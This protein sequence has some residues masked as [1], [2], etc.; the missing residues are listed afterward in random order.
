MHCN[1]DW[2]K[3]F[4]ATTFTDHLTKDRI[5]SCVRTLNWSFKVAFK[6]EAR[7]Y[8][9]WSRLII[10]IDITSKKDSTNVKSIVNWLISN[11]IYSL[12]KCRLNVNEKEIW[13][14]TD[15]DTSRT[16]LRV[17]KPKTMRKEIIYTVQ[18]LFIAILIVRLNG[19]L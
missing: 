13:T 19:L 1:V 10:E 18:C 8:I 11:V 3:D 2:L 6:G 9:I 17:M 15:K 7:I 14:E 12:L 16:N 4:I 5:R